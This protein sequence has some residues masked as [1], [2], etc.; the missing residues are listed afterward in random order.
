M[1]SESRHQFNNHPFEKEQNVAD[2]LVH[3]VQEESLR[4]DAQV[5]TSLLTI[6]AL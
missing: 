1:V 6:F 4:R 2:D 3:T 5:E